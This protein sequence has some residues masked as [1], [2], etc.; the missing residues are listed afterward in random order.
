MAVPY[1]ASI[2]CCNRKSDHGDKAPSK[3]GTSRRSWALAGN[4][5]LAQAFGMQGRF[6]GHAE[7]AKGWWH[8]CAPCRSA[9]RG[10]FLT[11]PPL[12]PPRFLRGSLNETP[13]ALSPALAPSLVPCSCP[14]GDELPPRSS[15]RKPRSWC[16]RP[17][18]RLLLKEP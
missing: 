9:P 10:P 2:P 3:A 18:H 8:P 7:V 15:P 17:R 5:I 4:S 6:L 16:L 12:R 14:Y 1:K 13:Q 11:A